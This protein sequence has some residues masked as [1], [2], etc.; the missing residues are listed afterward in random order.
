MIISVTQFFQV[1]QAIKMH[2]WVTSDYS[3]HVLLDDF[4]KDYSKLVDDIVENFL[5]HHGNSLEI[6]DVQPYDAAFT[7]LESLLQLA[8]VSFD[9]IR[10]NIDKMPKGMR[11][12]L[13]EVDTT[14]R[15]YSYLFRKLPNSVA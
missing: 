4:L 1:Q 12:I 13:D 8:G 14:L 9:E 7:S 15:K 11:T 5:S 10:E 2:H 3:T 6:L